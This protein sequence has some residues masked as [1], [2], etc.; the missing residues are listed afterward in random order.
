MHIARFIDPAGRIRVGMPVEPGRALGIEGDLYA[1]HR[2]T[3]ERIEIAR[4]LAPVA[5]LNCFCIGLNYRAHAR[6]TGAP[7]PEQPVVFLK[8]TTAISNPGDPIP[9]PRACEHGPETDRAPR[10]QAVAQR[11]AL[12][13]FGSQGSPQG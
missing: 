2:L 6:E 5:L 13:T 1:D 12:E 9:I 11:S 3:D 7:I 4:P 10:A 8:P